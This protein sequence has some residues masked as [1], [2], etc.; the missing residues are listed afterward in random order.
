MRAKLDSFFHDIGYRLKIAQDTKKLLDKRLA[1]SFSL[2]PY[3]APNENRI[4]EIIRD[5]LDPN[6]NHG[7]GDIFLQK[8]IEI[9]EKPE[10]YESGD[11][12]FIRTEEHTTSIENNKRRIDILIEIK[13]NNQH[14]AGIAIENKPWAID[15]N[16]QIDDYSD[17]IRQHYP[18]YYIIY[19]TPDG[20][21]PPEHSAAKTKINDKETLLPISYKYHIT[22]WLQACQK[23]SQAEYV[24]Q[25]L[26]DF[27]N[28]C[29][30]NLDYHFMID[31]KTEIQTIS[32]YLLEK[33][34]N[35]N[36]LQ[37][38][39]MIANNFKKIENQ[40]ITSFVEKLLCAMKEKF[41]HY[42]IEEKS[43]NPYPAHDYSLSLTKENWPI[44]IEINNQNKEPTKTRPF[45]LIGVSPKT[46][47][48]KKGTVID[49][50][51]K[52]MLDNLIYPKIIQQY[53]QGR[54]DDWWFHCSKCDKFECWT[55]PETL[56]V[57]HENP[58]EAIDY[59]VEEF[60]KILAIVK[61][62]IDKPSEVLIP[63]Q[64]AG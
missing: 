60:S 51:K 58:Q 4:S 7:Q 25:F 49:K 12:A 57:L 18:N 55:Q 62:L 41:Q 45:F 31:D 14:H 59:F 3:I 50:N 46:E 64:P 23:E 52:T 30:H 40:I 29:Q 24:R 8:F 39:A 13:R 42:K 10:F 48:S 9:I 1:S 2:F 16:K 21:E 22:S 5:L 36:R 56:A 11:H 61:P 35:K 34:N 43:K 38:A 26:S 27:S 32:N 28:Y 20:R 19:L 53:K 63:C 17:H 44:Y 37:I 6:G 54:N 15:Q 33:S 47:I